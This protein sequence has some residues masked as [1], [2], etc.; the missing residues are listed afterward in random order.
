MIYDIRKR[1]FRFDIPD[2]RAVCRSGACLKVLVPRRRIFVSLDGRVRY[3]RAVA[4]LVGS[5]GPSEFGF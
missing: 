3:Q 1:P 5:I 2:L 4:V